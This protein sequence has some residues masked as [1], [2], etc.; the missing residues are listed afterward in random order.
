MS[1][2]EFT[3]SVASHFRELEGR[4]SQAV[5]E[6]HTMVHMIVLSLDVPA[7]RH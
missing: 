6:L 1:G 5:P 4:H 3:I 2:Q 7:F